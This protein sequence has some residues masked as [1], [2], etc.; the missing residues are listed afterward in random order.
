MNE[1][2]KALSEIIIEHF[3][4]D[5]QIVK[6]MEEL[7]ELILELAKMVNGQGDIAHIAEEMADVHVMMDQ[8][9]LIF[10]IDIELLEEIATEKIQRTLKRIKE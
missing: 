8:L 7:S 3:G 5:A 4:K 9:Q 2:S 6:A 1:I 10:D